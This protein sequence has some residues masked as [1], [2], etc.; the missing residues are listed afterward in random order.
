MDIDK[1][2]MIK[3]QIFDCIDDIIASELAND[4][5]KEDAL[6]IL[7]ALQEI[8]IRITSSLKSWNEFIENEYEILMEELRVS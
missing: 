4:L 2:S 6:N 3:Q 1:T 5:S 8:D 7:H